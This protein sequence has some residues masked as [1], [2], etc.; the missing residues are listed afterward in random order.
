MAGPALEG[1]PLAPP[2]GL[3]STRMSG[4]PEACGK[5]PVASVRGKRGSLRA[6]ER[7]RPTC[8]HL[9]ARSAFRGQA[10]FA[11]L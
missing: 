9:H 2:L 4:I 1:P 6:S 7:P 5:V 10:L 3:T 11:S 8:P